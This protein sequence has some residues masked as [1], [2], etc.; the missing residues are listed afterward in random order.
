MASSADGIVEMLDG[1]GAMNQRAS[2]EDALMLWKQMKWPKEWIY[3]KVMV[4]LMLHL[5]YLM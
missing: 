4:T 2:D 5:N 1:Q 3:L